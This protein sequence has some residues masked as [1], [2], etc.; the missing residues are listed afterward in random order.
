MIYSFFI[1]FTTDSGRDAFILPLPMWWAFQTWCF[2]LNKFHDLIGKFISA[3]MDRFP[4]DWKNPVGYLIAVT[5]QYFKELYLLRIAAC[6]L[7]LAI[8][9]YLISIAMSK[10]LKVSLFGINHTAGDKSERKRLMERLIEFLEFYSRA[11][12][13]SWIQLLNNSNKLIINVRNFH[14]FHLSSDL[15]AIFRPYTSISLRLCLFGVC[16]VYASHY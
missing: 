5:F 7:V 11:K 3:T 6:A 2:F 8:G 1:Y 16:R 12:Q 14:N 13:L 10:S 4:F 15:L 9:C